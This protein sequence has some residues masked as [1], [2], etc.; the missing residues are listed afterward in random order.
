MS[1]AKRFD[2]REMVESRLPGA[3]KSTGGDP[4]SDRLAAMET[5]M[6]EMRLEY[7]EMRELFLE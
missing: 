6:Q 2:P 3:L 7:R 1:A 5:A 4:V